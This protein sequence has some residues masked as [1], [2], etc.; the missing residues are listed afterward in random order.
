[1]SL[2]RTVALVEYNSFMRQPVALFWSFVYPIILIIVLTTVFG[3]SSEPRPL[4]LR[5]TGDA[6][7]AATI[8]KARAALADA[9]VAANIVTDDAEADATVSRTADGRLQVRG[10]GDRWEA[11]VLALVLAAET[12][13]SPVR[14]DAPAAASASYRIYL[15]AGVVAL[16][17]VTMALFGFT[18]VIVGNRAAGRLRWLAYWP[19]GARVFLIG[20]AASRLVITVVFSMAFLYFFGW[21]HG[22]SAIW[23]IGSFAAILWCVTVGTFCFLSLG[24]LLASV[25]TKPTTANAIVNIV[26]LPILFLSDFIIPFSLMPPW[27]AS[28]A[29]L[30]PVTLFV[31]W[32]R[33]IVEQGAGHGD[34]MFASVVLVAT[35]VLA[36]AAAIRLFR[37]V[38][39]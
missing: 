11:R 35:G 10:K 18:P 30:S 12:A 23:S 24:L 4:K 15:V 27:L 34:G 36:F 31:R 22:A 25:I 19:I 6:A 9:G 13:R 20:F 32:L 8:D 3:G 5:V 33:A 39:A 16:S 1:M 26:N 28:L 21:I 29:S 2:Q 7:I 37:L 17:I 38:D 14:F